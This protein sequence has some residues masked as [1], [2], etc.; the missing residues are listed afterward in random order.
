LITSKR[1][2][3]TTGKNNQVDKYREIKIYPNPAR[4]YFQ[5]LGVNESLLKLTDTLGRQFDI[6]AH[7]G[8]FDISQLSPGFYAVSTKDGL[9]LSSIFITL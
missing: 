7:D 5:L 3:I 4:L 6:V 9:F 1:H 2:P 8:K